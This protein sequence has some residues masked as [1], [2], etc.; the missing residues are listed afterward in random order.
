MTS[1]IRDP[2]SSRTLRRCLLRELGPSA[3]RSETLG[4]HELRALRR[5]WMRELEPR[6]PVPLRGSVD[7]ETDERQERATSVHWIEVVMVGEDDE[8]IPGLRYQIELPDGRVRT[9]RLDA[10]GK[11]RIDGIAQTGNCKIRFPDLD[12]EAWVP[13]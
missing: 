4:A 3:I 7:V 1:V 2:R 9:G 10:E 13:A 8:P 12:Q 6:A 11:A 5:G